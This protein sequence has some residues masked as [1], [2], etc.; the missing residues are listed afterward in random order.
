MA[1]PNFGRT[2]CKP[3]L[4]KTSMHGFALLVKRPTMIT[5]KKLLFL[6]RQFILGQSWACSMP[7]SW[8]ATTIWPWICG[9]RVRWTACAGCLS[10]NQQ[11]Q[12]LL[13]SANWLATMLQRTNINCSILPMSIET[14]TRIVS[15]LGARVDTSQGLKKPLVVKK[16][17]Q[18]KTRRVL[19]GWLRRNLVQDQE[20][21]MNWSDSI[22][23]KRPLIR[24]PR[25][26]S[27]GLKKRRLTQLIASSWLILPIRLRLIWRNV[28]LT[29]QSLISKQRCGITRNA[30]TVA[31]AAAESRILDMT[32]QQKNT[33]QPMAIDPQD[34]VFSSIREAFSDLEPRERSRRLVELFKDPPRSE[35]KT[36]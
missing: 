6:T 3:P 8:V 24:L 31:C 33:S 2:C 12:Q 7:T 18:L 20:F 22:A 13:V 4:C 5:W 29:L 11:N 26:R 21:L 10:Q 30:Y 15:L 19:S 14:T 16:A 34:P 35:P 28:V 32:K 1:L 27:T 9:G 36:P 17:P 23:L 25:R